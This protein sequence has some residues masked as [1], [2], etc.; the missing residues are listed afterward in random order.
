MAEQQLEKV[1]GGKVMMLGSPKIVLVQHPRKLRPVL[2]K[3][4]LPGTKSGMFKRLED[5]STWAIAL[6]AYFQHVEDREAEQGQQ[7]CEI[8]EAITKLEKVTNQIMTTY[9]QLRELLLS[10]QTSIPK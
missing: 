4:V 10:A 7:L 2:A 9:N 6:D 8:M 1:K 5:I 3:S